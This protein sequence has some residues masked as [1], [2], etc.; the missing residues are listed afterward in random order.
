MK[1]FFLP[2]FIL[3]IGCAKQ[4]MLTG[5]EKDTIAPKLVSKRDSLNKEINFVNKEFELKFNENIQYLKSTNSILINP[6]I[7]DVNVS[8]NKNVLLTK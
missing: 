2:I 6:N 7:K 5:G 4:S 1:K 3:F 8:V